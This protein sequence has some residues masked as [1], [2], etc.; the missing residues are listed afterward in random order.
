MS[1]RQ[2]KTKHIVKKI[3]L[4]ILIFLSA[5]SGTYKADVLLTATNWQVEK[6]VNLKKGLLSQ[7]VENQKKLWH[8]ENNHSYLY[9]TENEGK[10]N[11]VTGKWELDDYSLLISNEFDSIE[12]RVEKITMDEM[13][14]L[15]ADKD[16]VR[17][18]L[19]AKVKK[20]PVPDFPQQH[21]L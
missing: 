15:I 2:L 13:V 10:A 18:Y 21:N 9:E 8:F 6:V 12:V 3:I 14:W 16:S 5:C 11:Q 20:V 7:T 17:I 4:I 1:I 19:S